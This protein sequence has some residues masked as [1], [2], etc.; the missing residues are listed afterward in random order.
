[1][2]ERA[3]RVVA[4]VSSVVLVLVQLV[5]VVSLWVSPPDGSS[6][7]TQR[8]Y[9]T[10]QGMYDVSKNKNVIVLVVDTV[11]SLQTEAVYAN[12]PEMLDEFTG[13]TWYQNS[14]GS[15]I[16]TRNGIPF[17]LTG[18]YPKADETWNDYYARRYSQSTFLDDVAAQGFSPGFYSDGSSFDLGYGETHTINIHPIDASKALDKEGALRILYR[19]AFYRDMPMTIKPFF[20]YYTDEINNY[21][22]SSEAEDDPASTPYVM[23]D[24]EYYAKLK[25]QGLTFNDENASFRFI[26]LLG[27]HTPYTM[28]AQGNL[29]EEGTS[30]EDQTLGTFHILSEYLRQLKELGV[31]DQSTIIVTADHGKWYLTDG[32]ITEPT[33]PIIFVKPAQ[34]AGA[35]AAPCAISQEPASHKDLQATMLKGMGATQ[36]VLDHYGEF[37]VALED[38]H[39]PADRLRTYC[40]LTHD[41]KRDYD[42][43]EY[44]IVGD[45][46]DFNNW[47]LDGNDWR[48]EEAWK[49]REAE[50]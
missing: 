3:G 32:P 37:N 21:M 5:G 1:M 46:S 25:D 48:N 49:Q 41:G 24:P 40:M 15:L 6:I 35:D 4:A 30:L 17:L 27:T 18:S 38:R 44:Q 45:V 16:P 50:G 33:S 19:C 9:T 22:M 36:D 8:I 7:Q 11:D 43:L 13:F 28:D 42:L 31:Y 29:N 34:N 23:N 14:T 47:H 12:H 26:H 20:W 2:R 10:E 39:D